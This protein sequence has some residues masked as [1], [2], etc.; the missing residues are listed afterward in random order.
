MNRLSNEAQALGQK[1][2][3][4][5]DKARLAAYTATVFAYIELNRKDLTGLNKGASKMKANDIFYEVNEVAVLD[6]DKFIDIAS[7]CIDFLNRPMMLEG[8]ASSFNDVSGLSYTF[9]KATIEAV[10]ENMD[11]FRDVRASAKAAF[12]AK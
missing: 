12:L 1:I 7:K 4:T 10:N 11:T 2:S 9:G 6:K 5:D 8:L 3:I